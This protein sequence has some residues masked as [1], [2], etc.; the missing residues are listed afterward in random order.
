MKYCKPGARLEGFRWFR[1]LVAAALVAAVGLPTGPARAQ[2]PVP[3][4]AALASRWKRRRSG[5]ISAEETARAVAMN[6]RLSSS[7]STLE[8]MLSPICSTACRAS[9]TSRR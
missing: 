6:T 1:I 4:S 9:A 5:S 8:A 7:R 2:V 3:F